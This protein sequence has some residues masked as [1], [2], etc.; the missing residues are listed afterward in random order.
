MF[1]VFNGVL[2]KY[3]KEKSE[4][5]I[6]IPDN[7]SIIGE[8]AFSNCRT[9]KS[10]ELSNRE[11]KI[12]TKAFKNCSSLERIKLS[13]EL[14]SIGDEAFYACT[15]LEEI[16]FPDTLSQIGSSAFYGCKKINKIEDNNLSCYF[17]PLYFPLTF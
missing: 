1:K 16:I 6:T 3:I 10:V 14:I 4:Q 17:I 2:T 11:K 5:I 9:I 8:G 12:D 15:N 13:S 7:I